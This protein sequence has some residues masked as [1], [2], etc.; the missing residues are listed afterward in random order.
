MF[1]I[2]DDQ[3]YL[4]EILAEIIESFGYSARAFACP[5][6]YVDHVQSEAFQMPLGTITDIDM[7]IMN[8]YEMMEKVHHFKPEMKFIVATGESAIRHEYQSKACMYLTKPYCPESIKK[9]LNNLSK[10]VQFGASKDIG[11]A[12][13]D[14]RNSFGLKSWS[15]PHPDTNP[16]TF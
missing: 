13:C 5:Q 8:G 9:I 2:V 7:P 16:S 3:P 10:C 1:H 14:D 6:A 15:C 4:G 12:H 11:C